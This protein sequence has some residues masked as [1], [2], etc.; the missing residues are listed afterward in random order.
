MNLPVD[1]LIQKLQQ[2]GH[3]A[4]ERKNLRDW[5]RRS[6]SPV[7]FVVEVARELESCRLGAGRGVRER[8]AELA[9]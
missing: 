8:V 2:S 7:C 9:H 1:R 4:S 5:V 6:D 3:E